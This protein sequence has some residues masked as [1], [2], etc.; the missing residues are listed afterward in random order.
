MKRAFRASRCRQLGDAKLLAAPFHVPQVVLDLL[1]HP[2]LGRAGGQ[3]DAYTNKAALFEMSDQLPG[4]R[5]LDGRWGVELFALAVPRGRGTALQS[6]R[7]FA[8][9]AKSEGLVQ[10]AAERAGIRG[11]VKAE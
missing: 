3:V 11:I 5:V 8:D 9:A 1:I 4:S 10:R 7:T 6:V 2:T